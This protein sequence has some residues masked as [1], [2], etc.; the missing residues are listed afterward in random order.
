M[1]DGEFDLRGGCDGKFRPQQ[2]DRAG[3]KRRR[4]AGSAKGEGLTFGTEA[5]DV[6]AR[7]AQASSANRTA[8]IRVVHRFAST[9]TSRDRDHPGMPGNGGAPEAALIASRRNY[10]HA[11]P[12]GP[13]E[14]L[15]ERPFPF[16]GRLRE[17]EAQVDHAR[18]RVDTFDDRRGEFLGRCTR[19]YS[20]PE[21]VSLNIG[22]I[23]RV[24]SGQIAGAEELRFAD[25]IPATKVPCRQAALLARVHVAPL[26]PRISWNRS[27]VR[28][29]CWVRTGP[30]MSPILTSGLPLVRSINGTKLIISK[31][32]I[33]Q[34]A[35]NKFLPGFL[36]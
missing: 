4:D 1:G 20:R 34:C 15:F 32:V 27:P 5:G 36:T 17:S 13:I 8:Q 31:W 25:K 9:V 6:V 11:V 35:Q 28:S 14:R 10:D 3:H 24:Q 30:S 21:V 16:D 7:R 23:R 18:T 12:H 2:R 29:G 22:R 26:F 19:M 33:G